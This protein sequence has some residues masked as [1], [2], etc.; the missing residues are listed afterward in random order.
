M[1][2]YTKLGYNL[3]NDNSF[4]DKKLMINKPIKDQSSLLLFRAKNRK[5]TTIIS[6][7]KKLMKE[8][9][10][11][12]VI[13][14]YLGLAYRSK[15]MFDKA[16]I[17]YDQLVVEYPD[18]L[19]GWVG[20]LSVFLN[21]GECDKIEELAGTDVDIRTLLPER[22]VFHLSEVVEFLQFA[23]VYFIR[24]DQLEKA[25]A[26]FKD[27][28]TIDSAYPD[29]Q[30]LY[31]FI[32]FAKLSKCLSG[33]PD[34]KRN[35]RNILPQKKAELSDNVTPPVFQHEA[36]NNL[37]RYGVGIPQ[38]VLQEILELPRDSVIADLEKVLN[39]AVDRYG[40]FSQL[41]LE[42]EDA[43][44]FVLHAFFLLAELQAEESLAKVLDILAYD[45]DFFNLWFVPFLRKEM[46]IYF[47]KTGFSRVDEIKNFLINPVANIAAKRS[48]TDAIVQTALHHPEKRKEMIAIYTGIVDFYLRLSA[49]MEPDFINVLVDGALDGKFTSLLPQIKELYD[50]G[51][52]ESLFARNYKIAHHY[53][54]NAFDD[55][56]EV[57]DTYAIY[58]K[59][60]SMPDEN[61]ADNPDRDE[62]DD[63]YED[64]YDDEDTPIQPTVSAKIGR[65]DPCPC[66]SGKKYKKC[67]LGKE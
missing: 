15:E 1:K 9:P 14:D 33:N 2:T 55:K 48:I 59:I 7:L 60:T 58:Q 21:D 23:I 22:K 11:V 6:T 62:Y 44:F 37:Y 20:L 31:S 26:N 65:N 61:L 40:Y 17:V 57:K 19:Q 39:D 49:N 27:L 32:H 45:D 24:T 41:D 29:L 34:G 10:G 25:E 63:E 16:R 35:I 5:D 3:T 8:Y 4:R 56:K 46:W 52:V 42:D 12:P 51:Y 64:D 28:K 43:R 67:C 47:Y 50:R 66:G 36:I 30:L 13:K 38:E 54:T 18:F 53:I